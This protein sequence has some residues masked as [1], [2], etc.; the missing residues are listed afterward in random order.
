[1][2]INNVFNTFN[3]NRMQN[4]SDKSSENYNNAQIMLYPELENNAKQNVQPNSQDT[5]NSNIN[6]N[7]VLQLISLFNSKKMDITSLLSS[8]IGKKLGVNENVASIL[9]LLNSKNSSKIQSVSQKESLPKIDS[10][11]RLK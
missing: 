3:S 11:E 1:M 9:S 4:N 5:Q 6:L 7:T 2:N 8:P 10:L